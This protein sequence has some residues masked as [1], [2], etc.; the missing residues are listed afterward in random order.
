MRALVCAIVIIACASSAIAG[1]PI[2]VLTGG[3]DPRREAVLV[4]ALRIYTRDLGR[5]VRIAGAAPSAFDAD[6]IAGVAAQ[7]RGDGD[8]IV[9]WFGE[10]EREPVLLALV[11][12][13]GEL[14]ETGVERDEPLRTARAL[15]LKIRAL[16]TTEAPREWSVPPEARAVREQAA[17]ASEA[18]PAP[19]PAVANPPPAATN[20]PPVATNPP[21]TVANPRPPSAQPTAAAPPLAP[22][23]ATLNRPVARRRGDRVELH[24]EYGVVVPT[25]PTWFRHGLTVRVAVPL[26]SRPLALFADAAFLTA[27]TTTVDASSVTTRVWPVAVGVALRRTRP[28]WQLAG[29]PRVSLQIVD[30]AVN[31]ADGRVASARLYSAGVGL[32]GDVR[33]LAT[34]NIAVV[35]SLSAEA[36]LPRLQL[37]AGGNAATDLGWAQLGANAGIV[38]SAP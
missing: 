4:D 19:P 23:T 15:A 13:T 2:A 35:A 18:P 8:E 17:Q 1:G 21:P 25:A 20:P 27:P 11:V 5:T 30:A 36:L 28:R 38:F 10:R 16:L 34:R 24:A 26:G 9:V 31:A 29:G 7:A 33:W 6:A 22:S 37:A 12:A 14:R 32:V 3:G